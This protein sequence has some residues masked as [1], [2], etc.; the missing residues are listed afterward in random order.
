MPVRGTPPGPHSQAGPRASG[1]P[2]RAPAPP[3]DH[4]RL[5]GGFVTAE[6]VAAAAATSIFAL[7]C[8]LCGACMGGLTGEPPA[9]LPPPA[10]EP[11]WP[12]T[13][14][15]C[16]GSRCMFLLEFVCLFL[17][18]FVMLRVLRWVVV[19]FWWF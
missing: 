9:H 2:R 5:A 15:G 14:K 11:G 10:M 3:P 13:S 16:S 17:S 4:P 1:A 12:G 18:S 7:L 6:L 8:L 19:G